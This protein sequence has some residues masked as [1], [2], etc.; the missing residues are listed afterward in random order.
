MLKDADRSLI[1]PCAQRNGLPCQN[2]RADS[3]MGLLGAGVSVTTPAGDVQTDGKW[4]LTA[5][6]QNRLRRSRGRCGGRSFDN[7]CNL[8][9][10]PRRF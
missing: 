10:R 2:E 4:A 6:G 9:F 1:S 8:T 5:E 3:F 7:D